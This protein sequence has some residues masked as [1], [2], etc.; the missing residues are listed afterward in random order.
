MA[1]CCLA[2]FVFCFFLDT[3]FCRGQIKWF[4]FH[5]HFLLLFPL[6][7]SSSLSQSLSFTAPFTLPPSLLPN[8]LSYFLPSYACPSSAHFLSLSNTIC[9]IFDQLRQQEEI[10]SHSF[11]IYTFSSS[12]AICPSTTSDPASKSNCPSATTWTNRHTAQKH[13]VCISLSLP[14]VSS[15]L[16]SPSMFCLCLSVSLL[17]Q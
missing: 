14:G 11:I 16:F 1:D 9:W 6:Y 5:S 10:N 15:L 7:L 4:P 13:K 2:G 3:R 8:I 12:L 17:S